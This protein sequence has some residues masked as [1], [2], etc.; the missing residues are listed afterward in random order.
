MSYPPKSNLKKILLAE[1][2]ERILISKSCFPANRPGP[3]VNNTRSDHILS[4]LL[5]CMISIFNSG[6]SQVCCNNS[7]SHKVQYREN[8][9]LASH[10]SEKFLVYVVQVLYCN[11]TSTFFSNIKCSALNTVQCGTS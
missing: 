3:K 10:V 11:K 6:K 9:V 8:S 4:V 5:V 7:F 2:L 1:D